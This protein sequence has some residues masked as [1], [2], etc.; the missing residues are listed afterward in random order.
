MFGIENVF[1]F[2]LKFFFVSG[3]KMKVR[4]AFPHIWFESTNW[5]GSSMVRGVRSGSYKIPGPSVTC[6]LSSLTS[7]L[8]NCH[9]FHV[10]SAPSPNSSSLTCPYTVGQP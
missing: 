3:L 1:T 5:V 4:T 8:A 7:K 9:V 2:V 10:N 6:S